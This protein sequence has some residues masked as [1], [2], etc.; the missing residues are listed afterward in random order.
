MSKKEV[1]KGVS[2]EEKMW[3]VISYLWVLSLV[4]LAARRDNEFVRFHASQ[5]ALVFILSLIFMFIPIVGWILN[6]ILGIMAIIGII[7]AVQG[8]KWELPLLG[9]PAK[10]FGDWIVKS[11]KL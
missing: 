11:F 8:E 2:Q 9:A 5:G 6:I 1:S 3:G 10:K 4:A 7:N